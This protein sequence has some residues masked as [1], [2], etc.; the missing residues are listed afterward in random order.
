MPTRN[1]SGTAS[2][3]GFGQNSV[4]NNSGTVNVNSGNFL[5]GNSGGTARTFTPAPTVSPPSRMAKFEPFS[6]ATGVISSTVRF[7]SS[8]GITISTPA[9]SV[10]VPVTSI[11]RM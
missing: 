3:Q 7:T 4:F 11:V 8:P 2:Q 10:I 5:I 9:G 6:S 1:V